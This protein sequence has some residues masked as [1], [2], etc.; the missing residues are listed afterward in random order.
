MQNFDKFILVGRQR[1]PPKCLF[2][3]GLQSPAAFETPWRCHSEKGHSLLK[4][5]KGTGH[6]QVKEPAQ[7]WCIEHTHKYPLLLKDCSREQ[8]VA[9]P[10]WVYLMLFWNS[11]CPE[12]NPKLSYLLHGDFLGKWWW[13]SLYFP[14]AYLLLQLTNM[15]VQSFRA[16][17]VVSLRKPCSWEHSHELR[18]VP[19]QHHVFPSPL[20]LIPASSSGPQWAP[21]PSGVLFSTQGWTSYLPPLNPSA[22]YTFLLPRFFTAYSFLWLIHQ[23]VDTS[24]ARTGSFFSIPLM[25]KAMPFHT[26]HLINIYWRNKEVCPDAS[27]PHKVL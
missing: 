14:P 18:H 3:A 4:G 19:R 1:A 26:R 23:I 16:T 6:R 17:Q 9:F 10:V 12:F 27:K 21:P 20:Q 25:L 22:P 15:L 7:D 5:R 11:L 2:L 13:C 8:G 24:R